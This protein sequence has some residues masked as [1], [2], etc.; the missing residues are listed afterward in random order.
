VELSDENGAYQAVDDVEL[1]ELM[2]DDLAAAAPVFQPPA[3]RAHELPLVA[4]ELRE[5]LHDF[6]RRDDTRLAD[7]GACDA[8]PRM[9]NGI[10]ANPDAQVVLDALSDTL[11]TRIAAGKRALVE[12]LSILDLYDTAL[13]IC[14]AQSYGSATIAPVCHL[15]VSR[16]GNP[17]GFVHGHRFLTRSALFFY[18]RYAY[19]AEHVNFRQIDTVVELGAGAGKQAEVLK[20]LH[21]HLTI[22]LLDTAPG[23]YVAE[24]FLTTAYPQH[25]VPYRETRDPGCALVPGHIH[26]FGNFRV[27]DIAPIGNTLFWSA[28]TLEEME[29]A[30]IEHYGRAVTPL[31]ESLYLHGCFGDI[32]RGVRSVLGAGAP[33]PLRAYADAF[34]EHELVDRRVAHTGLAELVD[35]SGTYDDTF[36]ARRWT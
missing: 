23:L 36:W 5:G 25:T 30:A 29:P 18:M 21:P 27:D 17:Y 28:A 1:L 12:G 8:P 11:N 7:L 10:R 4:A 26:F 6:R 15:E 14:T 16:V 9:L 35:R 13:R 22:V 2:L 20:R 19:V 3:C 32:R 34:P 31:A 24:R 33:A